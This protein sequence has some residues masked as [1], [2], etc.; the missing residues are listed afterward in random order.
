MKLSTR[1]ATATSALL[2]TVVSVFLASP[3]F[4]AEGGPEPATGPVDAVAAI[5]TG[6]VLLILVLVL[7]TWLSNMLG[8]RG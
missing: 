3:A 2:A 7:A 6:L 5:V 4:A 8:K 1:I